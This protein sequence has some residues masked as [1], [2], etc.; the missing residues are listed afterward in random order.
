MFDN[1]GR[2]LKLAASIISKF[3]IIALVI[4]TIVFMF[5]SKDP[6]ALLIA[7]IIIIIGLLGLWITSATIYG[8]GQLIENTDTIVSQQKELITLSKISKIS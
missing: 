4:S 2:K 6:V 1:I 3:G 5:L 8:L 7:P